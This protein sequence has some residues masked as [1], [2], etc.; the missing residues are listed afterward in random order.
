MTNTLV[1]QV[2]TPLKERRRITINRNINRHAARLQPDQSGHRGHLT[3]GI[4][5]RL[6]T[7]TISPAFI[8]QIFH[9]DQFAI[10]HPWQSWTQACKI[11][12]IFVTACTGLAF[13]PFNL[14]KQINALIDENEGRI[15]EIIHL[16][17]LGFTRSKVPTR[18]DR[19]EVFSKGWR[20]GPGL[21]NFPV[22]RQCRVILCRRKT[23][24][25]SDNGCTL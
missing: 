24:G 3:T 17:N 20:F 6:R 9:G 22:Y 19:I 15:L 25:Q 2:L 16:Q 23:S 4:L 18:I 8:H 7:H 12:Y 10:L 1:I 13:G 21:N 11:G 5:P 14:I